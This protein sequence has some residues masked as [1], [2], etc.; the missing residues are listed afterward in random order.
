VAADELQNIAD[1]ILAIKGVKH[2]G[3]ELYVPTEGG[4]EEQHRHT[5][6][7]GDHEH[8]HSHSHPMRTSSR[9]GNRGEVRPGRPASA[10]SLRSTN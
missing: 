1:R 7:H 10:R 2:G 6:R 3:I 4:V 5:H 9:L 8:T